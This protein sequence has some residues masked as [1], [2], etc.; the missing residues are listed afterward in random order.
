M[1]VTLQ[2]YNP[3]YFFC[4]IHKKNKTIAFNTL[5]ASTGTSTSHVVMIQLFQSFCVP[6]A[7]YCLELVCLP[8]S[9]LHSLQYMMNTCLFKILKTRNKTIVDNCLY[10]R[11]MLSVSYALDLKTF[12]FLC[13]QSPSTNPVPRMLYDINSSRQ[14]EALCAK[15]IHSSHVSD[16]IYISLQSLLLSHSLTSLY[17]ALPRFVNCQH[18]W[19]I[20]RPLIMWLCNSLYYKTP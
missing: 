14:H 10:Y 16:Q 19:Y 2:I 9:S 4:C 3:K 12:K 11:N 18:H 17:L 15:Y 5:Y 1:F 8:K 7:L 6:I 13:K 20:Y